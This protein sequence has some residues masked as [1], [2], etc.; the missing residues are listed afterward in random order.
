MIAFVSQGIGSWWAPIR[1]G[2]QS[3]LVIISLQ[4]AIEKN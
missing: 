4:P 2:T 3:E 1:I